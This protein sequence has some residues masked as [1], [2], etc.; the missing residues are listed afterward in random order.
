MIFFIVWIIQVLNVEISISIKMLEN[1][2]K[3]HTNTEKDSKK[4]GWTL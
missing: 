2:I 1:S 3:T 4:K